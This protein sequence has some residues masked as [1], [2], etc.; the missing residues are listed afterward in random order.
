MVTA[1]SRRLADKILAAFNHACEQR[2]LE[3]AEA[4]LHALEM[5]LTAYG[6]RGA[7]EKRAGFEE[8]GAAFTRFERMRGGS[9]GGTRH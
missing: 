7:V 4:L 1:D 3:V 5:S 8:V 6:G 9:P 2:D